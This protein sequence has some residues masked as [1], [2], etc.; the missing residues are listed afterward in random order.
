M[1]YQRSLYE[2]PG[3]GLVADLVKILVE[4]SSRSLHDRVQ[5]LV[6]SVDILNIILLKSTIRVVAWR[7][8]TWP[9][10]MIALAGCSYR[11]FLYTG[12]DVSA[13]SQ[14]LL[15]WSCN[16]FSDVFFVWSSWSRSCKK[17]WEDLVEILVQSAIT[18]PS[19]KILQMPCI[20]GFCNKDLEDCLC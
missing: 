16:I 4:S 8:W 10:C 2:D 18:G 9:V 17:P 15:W 11:R 7:S 6:R 14:V 3:Q 1:R 19:M 5:V 13:L 12:L 20:R